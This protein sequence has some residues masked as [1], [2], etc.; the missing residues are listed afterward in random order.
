MNKID[1][2]VHAAPKRL[3][4]P[5]GNPRT[6]E[7]NY[8]CDPHEMREALEERGI[9]RAVLMSSGEGPVEG[10]HSL[11]AYN[12]DCRKMAEESGGFF[13]WMCGIDPRDTDTIGVRLGAYKE[14]GAV[15]VGEVMVNQWLDS[16]YMQA[17]FTAAE[18]L[19]MPVLCHMSPA[20]GYS[21]GAADYPGLPLLEK[22]L[23]GHPDLVFIGHSQVFWM[24]ISGNCPR[25]GAAER[26]GFGRGPVTPGGTLERLMDAY[27]NLCADLSAYSGS[28]AILRD[29]QY[30]LRFLD[31]YQDR[32]MYG[33]DT[34]NRLTGFPLAEFMERQAA[35]GKLAKSVCEKIFSEN[36]KRILHIS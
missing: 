6:P 33:T 34:I 35:L 27:P 23:A 36:A 3:E 32:L 7:A 15:G 26:N 25:T 21:Y 13:R 22:T 10:V 17:L 8:I 4:V 1:I 29:E 9:G 28:C 5:F 30:G 2:H 16:P 31:K 12:D 20:E 19:G 24:E 18:R 14:Q 11:G